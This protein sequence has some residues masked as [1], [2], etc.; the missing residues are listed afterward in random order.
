MNSDEYYSKEIYG[1]S[2][3][4]LA[5][6]Q[7][8]DP[9]STY[10]SLVYIWAQIALLIGFVNFVL[11]PQWLAVGA[12]PLIFLIAGR[13][14]FLLQ[15]V[16]EGA[17]NLLHVDR[18]KNLF[19][20]QWFCGFPIGVDFVGYT[21][22]HIMHHAYAG[23]EKDPESD[24]DKYRITDF[25][26]PRLFW[27]FLKDLFGVSAILVFFSY[28]GDKK[29][30]RHQTNANPGLPPFFVK[31]AKL[32]IVQ[33]VILILFFQFDVVNYIL[34]WIVPA[35]TA[36]MVLM[37][38]RGI[39]EH[40]LAKQLSIDVDRPDKGILYTRSFYTSKNSYKFTPMILLEKL[41]IGTLNVN[42]HHEHHVFPKV[43]H[44]NLEKAHRLIRDKAHALNPDIYAKGYFSA[45]LKSLSQ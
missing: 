2:D 20:G 24:R 15:L 38:F 45:A 44:Y 8:L 34:F 5:D 4:Q 22:G 36:H 39:A 21:Q 19:L 26:N 10:R 30:K 18:R 33:S 31:L 40:G 23:T 12:V 6:L 17:H 35:A 1:L 29:P 27:L 3:E 7:K 14:G 13:Q 42:F 28:N 11:P 9:G 37:R 25:K 41:L 43:P 32:S 16:H